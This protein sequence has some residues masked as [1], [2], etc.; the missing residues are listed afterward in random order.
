MTQLSEFAVI[1]TTFI[2]IALVVVFFTSQYTVTFINQNAQYTAE[3]HWDQGILYDENGRTVC[4]SRDFFFGC[5][6]LM[7]DIVNPDSGCDVA[8]WVHFDEDLAIYTEQVTINIIET[9]VTIGLSLALLWLLPKRVRR[10]RT[11]VYN[12]MV[13]CH[14]LALIFATVYAINTNYAMNNLRKQNNNNEGQ[15]VQIGIGFFAVM[16]LPVVLLIHDLF[17]EDWVY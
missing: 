4:R 7:R 2:L 17:I 1:Q 12:L 16:I 5:R 8:T 9:T 15:I 6:D 11:S 10:W 14:G 13:M 3:C